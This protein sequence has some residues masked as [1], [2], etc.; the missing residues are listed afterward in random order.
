MQQQI[1]AMAEKKLSNHENYAEL[2][3]NATKH[4][5]VL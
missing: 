5:D 2:L 4:D 3:A 1:E